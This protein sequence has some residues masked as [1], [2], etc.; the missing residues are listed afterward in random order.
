MR[1]FSFLTMNVAGDNENV[2]P[3]VDPTKRLRFDVSKLAQWEIV[4]EHAFEHA[5]RKGMYLHFKMQETENDQLLDSGVLG[6]ERKLYCLYHH[7]ISNNSWCLAERGRGREVIVYLRNGGIA[8][9]NLTRLGSI[10]LD[11][12]VWYDPQNGGS[13]QKGTVTAAQ[14]GVASQSLSLP[15]NNSQQD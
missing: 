12:L 3:Y 2:Y 1:L 4:F 6:N 5:V 14:F 15:L 11:P 7:C 9:V 13:L 10:P 8:T